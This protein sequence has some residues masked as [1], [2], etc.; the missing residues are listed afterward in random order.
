MVLDMEG[1]NSTIFLPLINQAIEK[2]S[3]DDH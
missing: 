1:G 3:T 2:D